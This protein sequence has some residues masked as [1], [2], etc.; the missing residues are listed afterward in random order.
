[1]DANAHHILWGSSGTNPRAERIT[2]F[3]VSSN[4][5]ILNKCNEFSFVVCNIKEV[6]D[7]TQGT[8]KIGNLVSNWH[9]SGEPSLSAHRYIRFQIDNITSE[10]VTF[11]NQRRN[12][13][14]SYKDDLNVNLEIISRNIRTIKDI[15]RSVDQ[16]QR[17]IILSYYHN[18]PAKASCLPRNATWLNKV[19]S[20]LIAKTRNL[21]NTAK[22]TGQ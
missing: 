16:L 15:D 20:G 12:N 21:F 18:F 2:E 5:N 7:L 8:N 4:L 17:A 10:R 14:E 11:R 6:I 22:R 9:V 3:L 19:L 1:V 13:W